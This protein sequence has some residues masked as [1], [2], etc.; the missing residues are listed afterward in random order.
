VTTVTGPRTAV[1]LER[2]IPA[3]PAQVYRAWLDPELLARWM[4]PGSYAVTWA[5]VEERAG[6]RYRIW[7]ADASGTDV[8]GFDCELAELVPD[9]RIVFRWGFVGPQR[10]GGPAFDSV[11]TVTLREAPGGGTDLTLEHERLDDLAA[12][13]PDVAANVGPGWAD[14]L[15]KLAGALAEDA[16]RDPAARDSAPPGE[17]AVADLA[18]PA[19]QELLRRQALARLA[20]TGPDGFPR[21][22]P[23]GFV[24]RDGR[25]IVCTAPTAP[26]VRALSARPQVALTVDTDDGP[27]SRAL[28]VRGLAR[29]E[30]V[31]G[32]PEEYLAASARGIPAGQLA[33]FEAAVRSMYQQM[34]RITIEPR[35]A[36]YYDFGA[37]RIPRFLRE[38]AGQ[39]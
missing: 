15:G 30:V 36:R 29:I 39:V 34:A 7:H 25:I 8:G 9:E 17:A 28:L 19:A 32:V 18:H 21:V 33:A 6:G 11:L 10:R 5:E 1:H 14:V 38:L 12:A 3:P 26:K 16:S 37:G 22:I 20:Y 13:L 4:A 35:W 23:I 31:D 2:T 27:A 24:W